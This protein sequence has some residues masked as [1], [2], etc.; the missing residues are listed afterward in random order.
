MICNVNIFLHIIIFQMP[1]TYLKYL[2]TLIVIIYN[3]IY[4]NYNKKISTKRN[5]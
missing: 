1:L 5:T 4:N 2:D 3:E